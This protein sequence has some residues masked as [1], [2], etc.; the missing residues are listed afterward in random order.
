MI[1]IA[2]ENWII[3]VIVIIFGC[4]IPLLEH[5]M[6]G[7]KELALIEKGQYK[8]LE[9]RRSPEEVAKYVFLGGSVVAGIGT[10]ILIG[11]FGIVAEVAQWLRLGGLIVLFIGLA[12]LGSYP[13]LKKK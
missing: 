12:L 2:V 3:P 7:K 11:S 8:K 10:A 1:K 4:S 5:Y 9:K 13:I 6:K